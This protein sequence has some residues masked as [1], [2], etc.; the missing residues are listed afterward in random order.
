M[1]KLITLLSLLIGW[2]TAS[3]YDF[4]SDGIYYNITDDSLK[5]VEVTRGDDLHGYDG[6]IINIPETVIYNDETY[7][8]TSIGSMAFGTPNGYDNFG[9]TSVTIG[10]S[11]TTIEEYAFHW[12]NALS[13]VKLGDSLKTIGDYA[14]ERTALTSVSIGNS[15]ETIGR[16]AFSNCRTLTSLT[17]GNN[18]I[19]IDNNAFY[20]CVALTKI[21]IPASVASVGSSAFG[22][23]PLEEIRIECKEIGTWF[24]NFQTIKNV[25]FGD[26]VET[27]GNTAFYNCSVE[28][29]NLPSSLKSIGNQAFYNNK[30]TNLVLPK[31]LESVGSQAFYGCPIEKLTVNT[32]ANLNNVFSINSLTEVVF[33]DDATTI[34][35]FSG[36]TSLSKVTLPTALEILPYN[37]FNGCSSL[38]SIELPSSLTQI[39][40]NAF[41]NCRNLQTIKIPENVNSIGSYA[42]YNCSSLPDL[43]LPEKVNNI[44][45]Y[46]FSGCTSFKE[47]TLPDDVLY[48]SMGVF[49][50][51]TNLE[52]ISFSDKV[53]SIAES[54]FA[55]C[56]ALK[57]LSL[58]EGIKN[59][60]NAM[61]T[62]CTSITE[63]TIPNSV[64]AIGERSL[65]NCSSLKDVVLG[66][67][68]YEIGDYAFEGCNNIENI[69]CLAIEPPYA[70]MHTF[71]TALYSTATITV[72]EQ[73]LKKYTRESPWN[74]FQKYLTIETSIALSHYEVDMAGDEVFQLGVYGTNDVVTWST[75]NP[76]VA[77]ANECGLIVA[78]GPTGKAV[79]SATV[80]DDTVNCV[81]TV[82][83]Q[84]RMEKIKALLSSST[85]TEDVEPTQISIESI[86]GTPAI[87]N[88]RLYPVGA[89]T[90]M[91]WS[92][93]DESIATVE[94]GIVTFTGVGEVDF[95]VETEN[96]LAS[97]LSVGIDE[98]GNIEFSG[99]NDIIYDK[100]IKANNNVY[101]LMGRCVIVNAT[102]EQIAGLKSGIYIVNG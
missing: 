21:T 22:G 23:C 30:I 45:S 41:S 10:D 28:E 79:I 57:S 59:I 101:D 77:Y 61:L 74:R 20:D 93:S 42:F 29:L 69:K 72:P 58:P 99:L 56:S 64:Q 66:A 39:G 14:F 48:I 55:Y 98:N 91:N 100:D 4:E 75:S 87:L 34:P 83:A 102:P 16:Y 24:T 26:D 94:N 84:K 33:G 32:G 54:A 68:L 12:C 71:P 7:T 63:I 90:V 62:G 9:P 78:M 52:K 27:I 19:S 89:C 37:A 36:A 51:C 47:M 88:V 65:Y 53:S 40:Q 50:N 86:S 13:S 17:L 44:G 92:V 1:K 18:V 43:S 46:A 82:S 35:S 31:S 60:S 85:D 49:Q 67:G 8:V 25:E 96:G 6:A 2:L 95:T 38:Q 97:T 5:T 80:G 76:E 73:S 81:V 11:V 15:V 70:E 3:A